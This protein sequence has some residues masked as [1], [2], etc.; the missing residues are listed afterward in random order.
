MAPIY[1]PKM[2]RFL[3]GVPPLPCK[4]TVFDPGA[5]CRRR[6]AL[7]ETFFSKRFRFLTHQPIERVA[8]A[9]AEENGGTEQPQQQGIFARPP[10]ARLD[11]AGPR[12]RL[13]L[14]VVATTS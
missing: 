11:R 10:A 13:L 12:S 2:G 1:R 3:Q 5:S 4:A 14:P 7:A 6:G 8:A 9:A